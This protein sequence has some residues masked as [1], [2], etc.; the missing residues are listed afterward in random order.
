MKDLDILIVRMLPFILYIQIGITIVLAWHG[1]DD[2]PFN[3]LHSN[4]AIYALA[5]FLISLANKRYHCSWNRWMY[6][7]L[8]FTP[9]FNF[10]EGITNLTYDMY[11]YFI[12]VLCIYV[13][14]GIITSY[15]AIR[16]FMQI[17]K[18]KREKEFIRNGKRHN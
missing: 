18:L 6:A 1:I 13:L 14:V 12:V 7:Y 8:I 10:I 11:I 5:L 17:N 9:V 15:L 16:H 2:Y 3:L 4:S